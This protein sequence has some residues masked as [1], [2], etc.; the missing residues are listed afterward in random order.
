MADDDTVLAVLEDREVTFLDPE[1]GA[2]I[3][4]QAF[5]QPGT[6]LV[7]D[8]DPETPLTGTT[9]TQLVLTGEEAWLNDHSLAGR[10][11]VPGVR[12]VQ[13]I[14]EAAARRGQ[15]VDA[16]HEVRFAEPAWITE[17]TRLAVERGEEDWQVRGADTVHA[18]ARPGS[19]PGVKPVDPADPDGEAHDAEA[20]Y[21]RLFH[22]PRFQVLEDATVSEAHV[23]AQARL[24]TGGASPAA[25]AVEAVMQAA[26]LAGEARQLPVGLKAVRFPAPAPDAEVRVDARLVDRDETGATWDATVRADDEP[27]AHVR[28][29]RLQRTDANQTITGELV[30][31]APDDVALSGQP[32]DVLDPRSPRGK[33]SAERS[34]GTEAAQR[35]LD[36]ALGPEASLERD[37]GRPIVTG[38]DGHVSI[39]HGHGLALA[40]AHAEE[41]VGLDLETI[42]PRSSAWREDNLADEERALL[43]DTDLGEPLAATLAWTCKEASAKAIGTGLTEPATS[44]RLTAIDGDEA[45]VDTPEGPY[46]ARWTR[47]GDVVVTQARP[48]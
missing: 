3:F 22:G 16:L 10:P 48:E 29:L 21:E 46:T 15:P 39:T 1:Q 38:A 27:V 17:P 9:E 37:D 45:R 43:A 2:R 41:T 26:G 18:H 35:V 12:Y 8:L 13:A 34:A 42:E 25:L 36:E 11:L 20:I 40:A 31:F 30:P 19:G 6:H 23:T 24:D 28:G 47:I 32:V 7:A 4:Q 14:R 33:R 44:Y 5:T